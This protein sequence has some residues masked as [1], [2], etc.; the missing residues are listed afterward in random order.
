MN[1]LFLTLLDFSTL[2]ESGIYTDLL[3]EFIKNNQ[4][5]YIIS[6]T[7]KRK[8]QPTRL[9]ENDSYKILKLQ[10]GNTQKTNVIEKGISTLTL[11]SKFQRGIKDYFSNVKFDLVIY[12]TPP[13][14][15]QKAIE[16]VK[17]RDDAITYLLLKDIFPQN[18][19]DLG[20][21]RQTGV[22]GLLYKYFKSKEKRLYELSDYIGCMSQANVEFLLTQNPEIS[23]DIVEVCPNSIE[24]KVAE[25]NPQK[26]KIVK[27]KYKIPYDRTVFIYGGNLGKPQGIDFLIEC[28]KA[29]K[30]NEQVYFVIAGSGTE[31][32]KLKEFF[33]R[34]K[35]KNAQLFAHL[36]KEDYEIL[37]NSCDVG[38]IFLDKRFTIP[39]FP[40]RLLSYMQASMPVLA[41]TDVNTDIGQ[42]I[43]KGKFGLWC[44]SNSVE[45]FNYKLQQLCNMELRKE[46]GVNARNY[47][48]THYTSRE[49]YEIIMSH[50]K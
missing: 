50:F 4:K 7:E 2:D 33:D 12:T 22:G 13:I 3:R 31:F 18:A 46:M 17:K 19:I 42:V 10:I 23:P 48:E 14:T 44:E 20:M 43:E 37:A 36:P 34:E 45:Q 6:P 35:I 27:E 24:P 30:D 28:L 11:E 32:N 47:L 38:L 49:S 5:V 29:N 21:V 8:Q 40:S 16:Y 39:N 15:L 9:I 25:K 26:I 1:I 41:A